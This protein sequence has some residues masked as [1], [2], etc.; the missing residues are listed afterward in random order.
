MYSIYLKVFNPQVYETARVKVERCWKLLLHFT[1]ASSLAESLT[2]LHI[3][4]HSFYWIAQN[5]FLIFHAIFRLCLDI[6]EAFWLSKM[7]SSSITDHIVPSWFNHLFSMTMQGNGCWNKNRANQKEDGI[8][9]E[10][11]IFC[12]IYCNMVSCLS[13]HRSFNILMVILTILQEGKL[14]HKELLACQVRAGEKRQAQWGLYK[15]W[16][17]R[18]R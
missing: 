13:S 15:F 5:F 4:T 14:R 1:R 9:V 2:F 8:H 12:R 7:V 17:Y 11:K 16:F 18:H 6:L 3:T 10:N